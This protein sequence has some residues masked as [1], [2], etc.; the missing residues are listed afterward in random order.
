MKTKSHTHIVKSSSPLERLGEAFIVLL[1]GINVSGKNKLPM[2]ELRG[3]L[4]NLGFENV[5]TYIQSG[6]VILNSEKKKDE[7]SQLITTSI[8]EKYNYDIPVIVKTSEE[9]EMAVNNYPYPKENE[10]IVAFVF[11]EKPISFNTIEIKNQ[12]EDQYKIDKDIIYLYCPNGFGRSKLSNNVFESKL[13]LRATTRNLRTAEK[14]IEL[15]KK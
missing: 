2:V 15:S 12:G 4:M 6:N 7:I 5:Q 13:Q 3:M 9:L 10:K 11:L 8:K 14:L 1:R